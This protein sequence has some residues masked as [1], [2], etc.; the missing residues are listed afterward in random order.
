MGVQ[1]N[2][3][4][5]VKAYTPVCIIATNLDSKLVAVARLENHGFAPECHKLGSK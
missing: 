2:R 3:G 5:K 4:Y 1:N